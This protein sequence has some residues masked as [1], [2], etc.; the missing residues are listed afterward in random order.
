MASHMKTTVEIPDVL[1]RQVRKLALREGV[2]LRSLVEEGL[3]RVLEGRAAPPPGPPLQPVVFGGDG[4]TEEAGDGRW[5]RL[6]TILYEG[7]G[8]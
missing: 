6:R 8:E 7:R 1:F 2:T 5:E 3:R 4:F